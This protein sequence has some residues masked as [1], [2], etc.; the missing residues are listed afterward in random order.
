MS[1]VHEIQPAYR[2]PMAARSSGRGQRS[3]ILIGAGATVAVFAVVLGLKAML[4]GGSSREVPTISADERPIRVRPEQPGGM[5]VPN[6]DKLIFERGAGRTGQPQQQ[7]SLAPPP[8]TPQAPP[9]TPA[10]PPAPLPAPAAAAPAA[11][12][13]PAAQPAAARLPAPTPSAPAAPSAAAAPTPGG[14]VAVQLAAVG[15]REEAQAEWERLRRRAPEMLGNR[16]PQ[17]VPLERDGR[18]VFRLRT[19]GFADQAAARGFCEQ[20]RTRGLSCFVP[21]S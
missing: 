13:P 4:G 16:R 8:E 3:L 9:R 2:A 21:P 1:S 15:T 12:P 19:D 7:A 20:A 10:P 18:T 14:R 17:I 5:T 6:Q 11:P